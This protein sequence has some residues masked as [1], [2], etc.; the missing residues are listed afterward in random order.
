MYIPPSFAETDVPTLH[1]L[2]REYAFATLV[3]VEDGVPVASHVPFLLDHDRGPRGTLLGHLARANPQGR[4]FAGQALVVFAGPH[5][6]V[7]PSWYAGSP[8][9]PTWNYA[10]VHAYGTPRPIEDPAAVRA[11]IDRLVS[12]Y[13]GSRRPPWST[14]A[15]PA[16][17]ADRMFSAI[18]AFDIPIERLEG[19]YKLNQNKAPADRAGVIEGLRAEGDPLATAVAAL[20]ADRSGPA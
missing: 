14:A 3:T 8:N 4:S 18:V 5:A 20:M 16:D 13:E 12:V 1:A 6:Y 10:V 7:S 11:L 19:K 17:F 15:V 2:M 9:V